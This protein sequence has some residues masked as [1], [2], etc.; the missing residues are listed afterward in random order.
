MKYILNFFRSRLFYPVRMV[1]ESPPAPNLRLDNI[2]FFFIPKLPPFLSYKNLLEDQAWRDYAWMLFCNVCIVE[3][4]L[5]LVDDIIDCR[6]IHSHH[7]TMVLSHQPPCAPDLSTI[8]RNIVM[9]HQGNDV[10]RSVV[11]FV[12]G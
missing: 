2:E 12:C 3:M 8:S 6:V 11:T 9:N 10:P 7:H 4:G 5:K 1:S